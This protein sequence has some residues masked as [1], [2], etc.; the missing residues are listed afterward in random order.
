MKN[1]W[2]GYVEWPKPQM[3]AGSTTAANRPRPSFSRKEIENIRLMPSSLTAG[4]KPI[5]RTVA[6]GKAV[7]SML[8][9]GTSAG[10][11]APKRSATT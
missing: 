1:G 6:H 2:F 8:S 5:R 9:N 10:A 3:N 7:F 11:Q 4:R